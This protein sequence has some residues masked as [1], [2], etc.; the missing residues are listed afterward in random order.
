MTKVK[1]QHRPCPDSQKRR[2]RRVKSRTRVYAKMPA[3]WIEIITLRDYVRM[4]RPDIS[5]NQQS[6]GSRR[7]H[8]CNKKSD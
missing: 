2:L 1:T 5:S 3:K 4:R 7:S 8:A 6:R